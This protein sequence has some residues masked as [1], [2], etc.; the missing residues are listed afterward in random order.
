VPEWPALIS[1]QTAVGVAAALAE[2]CG[3]ATILLGV[4]MAFPGAVA[5]ALQGSDDGQK[6]Q[7][8]RLGRALLIGLE[9]LVAA[10]VIRSVAIAP[11]LD[12]VGVLALVVVVRTF[13]NWTLELE[14]EGRWPWQRDPA[15]GERQPPTLKSR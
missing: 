12:S 13:L 2:A 5:S 4:A 8:R 15:T 6:R 14:L 7:R 1:F 11:T 3:V 10:D 9:F